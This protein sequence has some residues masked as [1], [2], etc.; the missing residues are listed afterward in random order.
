MPPK[1]SPQFSFQ[2]SS[3]NFLFIYFFFFEICKNLNCNIFSFTFTCDP[4][5]A[6]KNPKA[7]P[8]ND[9]QIIPND[10]MCLGVL[11]F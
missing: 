5:R 11:K 9:F 4:M 6:N 10:N 8:S 1:F 3:Q 2:W 7:T